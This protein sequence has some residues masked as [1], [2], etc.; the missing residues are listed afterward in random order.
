M[1]IFDSF[2]I[3]LVFLIGDFLNELS[4]D[5]ARDQFGIY[6]SNDILPVMVNC[7]RVCYF[8]IQ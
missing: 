1:C 4:N 7:A 2:P 6:L 5:G 3:T 8:T